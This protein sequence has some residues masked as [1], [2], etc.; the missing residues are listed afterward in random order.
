M[1]ASRQV[2]IP[3]YRFFGRLHG[4][5]LS[6]LV[7]ILGRTAIP[8]LSKFFVPAAKRVSDDLS[9]FAVPENADVVS[10]RK[11]LQTSAKGVET[12]ILRKQLSS[13]AG[14]TV[15]AELFQQYLQN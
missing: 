5:G 7:Q 4:R 11:K 12:Q 14:K 13:V 6:A 15:P 8:F 2:E 10:G 3:T 1:V 9:D